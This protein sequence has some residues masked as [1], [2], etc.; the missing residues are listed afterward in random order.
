MIKIL[1]YFEKK[2]QLK[3]FIDGKKLERISYKSM[4]SILLNTNI[5]GGLFRFFQAYYSIFQSI[6]VSTMLHK[7]G[8]Y[9]GFEQIGF[10]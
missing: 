9:L 7:S 3:F 2:V 5:R 6:I 8:F 1:N 10:F 4:L